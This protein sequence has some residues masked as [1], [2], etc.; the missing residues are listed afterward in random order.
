MK[1]YAKLDDQGYVVATLT[2]PEPPPGAIEYPD[3]A[4]P[5]GLQRIRRVGN[6]F[7]LT[8]ETWAPTP[9]YDLARVRE[10]PSLGDQMDMLWHAMDANV[11][12][13]IEPLYSQIKAVKAAHPKP[14]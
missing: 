2:A 4:P 5:L 7:V 12:P 13:R 9:A 14:E 6:D 3:S 1:T 8:Q 11:I 10:Y